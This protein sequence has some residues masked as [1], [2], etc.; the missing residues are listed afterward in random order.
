[1]YSKTLSLN[2]PLKKKKKKHTHQ[3]LVFNTKLHVLLACNTGLKYCRMQSAILSTFIGLP[4][5]IASFVV[6]FEVAA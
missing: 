4:F 6:V 1:M 5:S 3:T 2:P